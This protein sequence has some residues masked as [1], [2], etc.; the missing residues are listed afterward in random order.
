MLTISCCSCQDMQTLVFACV[1]N[2]EL[3]FLVRCSCVVA[4]NKNASVV[5]ARL[6]EK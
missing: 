5:V 6:G 3:C 2:L 1:I 4:L